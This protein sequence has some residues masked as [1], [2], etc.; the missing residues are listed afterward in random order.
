MEQLDRGSCSSRLAQKPGDACA[1]E[2]GFRL[3][4]DLGDVSCS[5]PTNSRPDFISKARSTVM[6]THVWTV[7]L[8]KSWPELFPFP[9][10]HA[11]DLVH[12]TTYSPGLHFHSHGS[13]NF[14]AAVFEHCDNLIS[15]LNASGSR[16]AGLDKTR[17]VIQELSLTFEASLTL[18]KLDGICDSECDCL[19]H[20][21]LVS[22]SIASSLLGHVDV[23]RGAC[24]AALPE[25]SRQ[26]MPF[27]QSTRHRS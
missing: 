11:S 5:L 16:S 18:L 20:A 4:R 19:T 3:L 7:Y 22:V 12:G 6:S 17:K 21:K 1:W 13:T 27:V 26:N 8:I 25:S 15:S 10:I 24:T 9:V 23:P 14:S 2:L